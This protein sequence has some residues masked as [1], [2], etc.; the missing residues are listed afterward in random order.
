[1]RAA[2]GCRLIPIEP[3]AT[4]R[5]GYVRL[6]R[7]YLSRVM[8]SFTGW[9][10][11]ASKDIGKNQ[12]TDCEIF[13][14]ILPLPERTQPVGH[15]LVHRRASFVGMQR[16]IFPPPLGFADE[17]VEDSARISARAGSSSR[18]KTVIPWTRTAGVEV[19]GK[20]VGANGSES[21]PSAAT[22][23]A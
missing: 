15:P 12:E 19:T 16:C 6:E 20:F 8:E 14:K 5:I 10:R 4:R 9:L 11:E 21:V 1:M 2:A 18:Q 23:R 7:R 17:A 13:R 22:L 3:K